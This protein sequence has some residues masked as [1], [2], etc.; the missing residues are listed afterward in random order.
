MTKEFTTEVV[1]RFT[2]EIA[3]RVDQGFGSGDHGETL[4]SQGRNTRSMP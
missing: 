3:S 1:K 4:N 2:N